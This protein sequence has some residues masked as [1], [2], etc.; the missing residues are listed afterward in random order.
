MRYRC[1]EPRLAVRD[2]TDAAVSVGLGLERM[3]ALLVPV[4]VVVL[5]VVMPLVVVV[6]V[7]MITGRSASPLLT[8]LL[9]LASQVME[10]SES[11]LSGL[12]SAAKVGSSCPPR[13]PPAALLEA[14]AAL[15]GLPVKLLTPPPAAP[16]FRLF[17]RG[18]PPV[19]LLPRGREWPMLM[20][21]LAAGLGAAALLRGLWREKP[22]MA[23]L[24][25][26]LTSRDRRGP[27]T[28]DRDRL[29]LILLAAPGLG[30]ELPTDAEAA[31]AA[32]EELL[33]DLMPPVR[34]I[35]LFLLLIGLAISG[36]PYVLTS[37]W[38]GLKVTF[39][40]DGGG[41]DLLLVDLPR[42]EAE[43]TT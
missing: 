36:G 41:G 29:L 27:P 23:R 6:L 1:A 25:R 20:L 15:V 9:A 30:G 3:A 22:W 26:G 12:P 14:T 17:T 40:R 4:V 19:M 7:A 24:R 39:F 32:L 37:R 5:V 11:R 35:S 10:V 33:P 2:D 38:A 18:L 31:A 16:P 13:P 34:G 42:I 8:V 43:A 21:L 28:A